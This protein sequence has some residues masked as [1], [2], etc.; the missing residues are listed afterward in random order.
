MPSLKMSNLR[1][2]PLSFFLRPAAQVARDLLGRTLLN[3][4]PLG[5]CGGVIV[6][7]EAYDQ[8]D[9]ASHSAQGKTERNQMMFE[10]GGTAYVY[11]S[12]G[13]HWCFNVTTGKKENGAAVLIRAIEPI[14]GIEQMR[15]RRLQTMR[16]CSNRDLARGPGRLCQALQIDD[17]YNGHT[18]LSPPLMLSSPVGFKRPQYV[19][20]P[21]IGITKAT[22]TPWRFCVY[23]S[24]FLSGPKPQS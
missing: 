17:S 4:T 15:T 14:I 13:V 16:D 22:E 21:R 2:L 24:T 20:T 1:P 19:T 12:Y 6:E 10:M 11:R 9:P 7:T 5:L 8:S 3:E 18:L 23:K